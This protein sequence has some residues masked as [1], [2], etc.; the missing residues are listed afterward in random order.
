[1]EEAR[2]IL[3]DIEMDPELIELKI[4]GEKKC[5]QKKT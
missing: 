3:E 5:L 4:V 2:T 1:V